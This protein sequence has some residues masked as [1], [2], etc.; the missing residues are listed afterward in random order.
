[1]DKDSQKFTAFYTL[2]G[3]FQVNRK[4]V[5]LNAPATFQR[6]MDTALRGL[7]GKIC[8]VYLGEILVSG[9]TLQEHNTNLVTLF[10]RLRAVGLTLQPDKCEFLRPEL[11]YLGHLITKDCVKPNPNKI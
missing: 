9:G 6:M 1:M 11:E 5:G 7:V 8:F 2:H 10:E 3:H 4:L